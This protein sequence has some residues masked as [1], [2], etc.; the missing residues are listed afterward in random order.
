MAH[1]SGLPCH[2]STDEIYAPQ[3]RVSI[4]RHASLSSR[5]HGG[6]W[7]NNK[8]LRVADP[9]GRLCCVLTAM[10]VS[11]CLYPGSNILLQ[12]DFPTQGF[13]VACHQVSAC[14]EGQEMA[15]G[16]GAPPRRTRS[17]LFD[18]AHERVE[19]GT[20]ERVSLHLSLPLDGPCT[21]ETD[22][23]KVTTTCRIDLTVEDATTSANNNKYS[24][25]RLDLPIQ[26]LHGPT[27]EEMEEEE[28]G[29]L[30]RQGFLTPSQESSNDFVTTDILKELKILSLLWVEQWGLL[31]Q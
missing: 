31:L 7:N 18:T 26:V 17:Y 3:G 2:V 16:G 24:N 30:E 9:R 11:P 12:L 6:S 1:S 5:L 21:L 8:T 22:L 15:F 25:L 10:G 29:T 28:E 20:T 14:L 23:V 13:E 4:N 27:A 19:M